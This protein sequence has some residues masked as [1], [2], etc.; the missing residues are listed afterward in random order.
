MH[1]SSVGPP[2]LRARSIASPVQVKRDAEACD[3]CGTCNAVCALGQSPMTDRLDSGC[4]RC[5][6]CVAAC[7]CDALRM[8]TGKPVALVL[9]GGHG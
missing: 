5:G 2:P 4:E 6:K 9:R 3:V 8:T 7:P 1:S